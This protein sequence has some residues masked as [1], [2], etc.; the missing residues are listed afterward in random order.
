MP[1]GKEKWRGEGWRYTWEKD[2]WQGKSQKETKGNMTQKIGS[3]LTL[4]MLKDGGL[5][6]EIWVSSHSLISIF[7]VK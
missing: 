5:A 3:R 7:S 2:N 4:N 6:A 1:K